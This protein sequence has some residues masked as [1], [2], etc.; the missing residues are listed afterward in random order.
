M[1]A[2]SKAKAKYNKTHYDA[3]CFQADKGTRQA[4]KEASELENISMSRLIM[5]A[6]VY[7]IAKKIIPKHNLTLP[8]QIGQERQ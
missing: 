7:Y 8:A 5:T 3:I 4:L 6:I 1:N 2:S